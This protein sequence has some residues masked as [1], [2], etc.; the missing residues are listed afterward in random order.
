KSVKVS[1]AKK[2]YRLAYRRGYYAV[3][4]RPSSAK[5]DLKIALNSAA[6][7]QELPQARQMVFATRVIP[8]GKP[9]KA[10]SSSSA[11]KPAA[12]EPLVELQRYSVDYA[13]AASE[14]RFG[15]KGTSHT[16]DLISM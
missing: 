3:D 10:A 11:G 2:G 8:L 6:M 5:S 16:T 4:Q 7:E 14:L 15:T 13:I 1:L 12:K 9:H